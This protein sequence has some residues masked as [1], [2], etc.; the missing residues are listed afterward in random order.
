MLSS[1]IISRRTRT[2]SDQLDRETLSDMVRASTD[3]GGQVATEHK[4]T[5]LGRVRHRR[6]GGRYGVSLHRPQTT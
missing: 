4:W 3:E 6:I 5:A 2:I 1:P